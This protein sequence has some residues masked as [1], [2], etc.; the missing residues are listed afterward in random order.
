MSKITVGIVA[1]L[2]LIAGFGASRYLEPP[3]DTGPVLPPSRSKTTVPESFAPPGLTGEVR[4][5]LLIPDLLERSEKL[6]GLLRGL[7]PE[8]LVPVREAYDTVLLDLGDTDLVLF[9]EWWARFDPR[10]ALGWTQQNWPTRQSIPV[11][12]AV[13]REWGRTDPVAAIAMAGTAPGDRVRLRWTEAAVRGWDEV[14]PDGALEYAESLDPGPAR[15]WALYVVAK[16]KVL[17]DGPEAAIA[18]AEG[19]SDD[20]PTFK[21]NAIRRVAG[22]AAAVDAT[23]AV[24]FA[25]RHLDGP[26]AKDLPRR[27]GMAWVRY[28][29]ESAFRW[30]SGLPAGLNRDDGVRETYSEWLA[31]DPRAASTWVLAAPREQWAD[32]ALSVYSKLVGIKK[33]DPMGG[34]ALAAEIQGEH[35]RSL[36]QGLIARHWLVLDEPAANAWLEQSALPPEFIERVRVI[37]DGL[38]RAY[39]DGE[40]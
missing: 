9:G 3:R 25:E 31:F 32:P 20:D 35:E 21:L 34:L 33:R 10:S 13:I 23:V 27:I 1:I 37:P 17:R 2:C 18:W 24:E 22:A 29:P 40:I 26:Y 4:Q 11:L 19:L 36:A 12:R 28:D 30:L 5:I 39:R 16:R 14:V 6:A 15:Q 7:G 8:A 38:R